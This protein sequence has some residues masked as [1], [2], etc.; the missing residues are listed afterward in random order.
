VALFSLC[1]RCV[2]SE[3]CNA[4]AGQAGIAPPRV[5]RHGC[6]VVSCR[7]VCCVSGA[8]DLV[9]LSDTCCCSKLFLRSAFVLF[10]ASPRSSGGGY[11]WPSRLGPGAP[12]A[13]RSVFASCFFAQP[14]RISIIVVQMAG[15]EAHVSAAVHGVFRITLAVPRGI[16]VAAHH[17]LSSMSLVLGASLF[18]SQSFLTQFPKISYPVVQVCL[19]ACWCALA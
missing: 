2:A 12:T 4:H 7:R 19:L 16:W 18:A 9:L 14:S 8:C 5:D 13:L 6:C 11:K 3:D 17:C 10:L 15:P 1:K